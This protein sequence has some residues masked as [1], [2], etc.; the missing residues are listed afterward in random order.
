MIKE[1]KLFRTNEVCTDRQKKRF[2][3]LLSKTTQ[4]NIFE[5]VINKAFPSPPIFVALSYLTDEDLLFRVA[6]VQQTKSICGKTP[7]IQVGITGNTGVEVCVQAIMQM[8]KQETLLKLFAHYADNSPLYSIYDAGSTY[9]GGYEKI[10]A[11]VKKLDPES[12]RYILDTHRDWNRGDMR[13]AF[14]GGVFD[15]SNGMTKR[16]VMVTSLSE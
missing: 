9:Y 12:H 8:Q 10:D 6:S 15:V 14:E 7:V 11:L 16:Q 1:N 5:Y 2:E 13:H 4:E 3:K